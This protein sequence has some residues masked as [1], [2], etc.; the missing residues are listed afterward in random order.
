MSV[1]DCLFISGATGIHAGAIN[2]GYDRTDEMC[3]GYALYRK[4]C[5][6]DICMEHCGGMW[7]VKEVSDKGTAVCFAYVAGGCEAEACTSRMWKILT[8]AL[9]QDA[10]SVKMVA[11][12]E[13]ERQVEHRCMQSGTC[14]VF[15]LTCC[16]F[17][18]RLLLK[19]CPFQTTTR[20]LL[21]W[22]SAAPQ[23]QML[24]VSTGFTNRRRR[25]GWTA[26][27]CTANAAIPA[28][29]WS[30]VEGIGRSNKCREKARLLASPLLQAAAQ[31]KPARLASGGWLMAGRFKTLL[32]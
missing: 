8:N 2:G 31:L 13:A 1:G 6:P 25:R 10:S 21:P 22:S 7:E 30:I 32:L 15:P 23:V 3:G 9:Y 18:R 17:L 4:R 11:G 14:C 20:T 16:V 26:A 28:S 27:C 24:P 5:D 19:R 12:A 29:A